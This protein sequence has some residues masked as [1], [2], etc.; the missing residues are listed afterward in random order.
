MNTLPQSKPKHLTIAQISNYNG[1]P[2]NRNYP[3]VID[4]L[5]KTKNVLDKA[6]NQFPRTLTVL[7]ELRFPAYW[8]NCDVFADRAE[9]IISQFFK[10]LGREIDKLINARKKKDVYVH[11]NAIRYIWA[12]E[13]S[14]SDYPHFHV[15]IFLN[16]QCFWRI[17]SHDAN[18]KGIGTCICVAWSKAIGL[19]Y[20]AP[21]SLV[22]FPDNG[23]KIVNSRS[24]NY[25]EDYKDLFYRLSYYSKQTTKIFN[26]KYRCFGYSQR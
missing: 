16:N 19:D 14:E 5:D 2:V 24:F 17:G 7:F 13:Q 8:R 21:N 9:N 25:S 12:R 15:A 4:Y 10:L 20:N 18:G 26:C 22:N 3:L 6:I 11:P 23:S 1:L